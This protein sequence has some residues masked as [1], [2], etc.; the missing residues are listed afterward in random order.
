MI[1]NATIILNGQM[2]GAT[3]D[4]GQYK[5]KVKFNTPYNITASKDS[6]QPVTVQKQFAQGNTSFSVTLIM[7]KSLDWGLITILS[8]WSDKRSCVVCSTQNMG[9]KKAQ[10]CYEKE[11]HIILFSGILN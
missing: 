5:T 6:Y 7:E 11:R 1:P 2:L 9:W 10:A 3:D 8:H 4:H